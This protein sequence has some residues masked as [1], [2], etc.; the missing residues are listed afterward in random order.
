MIEE[1]GTVVSLSEG[2][3]EVRT[4]RR[5][6]CSGCGAQSGCGTALMDR[7]LGRRV[8]TLRARN[9][10]DA[11]VGDRVVVGVS[12]SGLL[13]AAAAAYLVPILGLAIGGVLGQAVALWLGR[14]GPLGPAADSGSDLPALIGASLGFVL[15]LFWLRRYSAQRARH[16]EQDPVVVR[17]LSGG[18]SCQPV[19]SSGR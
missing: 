5:G 15:A 1:E 11:L 8:V 6:G 17:R 7:F 13:C 18:A 3:A 10:A 14:P 4:E 2:V 16:P 12:E 19:S 9:Q